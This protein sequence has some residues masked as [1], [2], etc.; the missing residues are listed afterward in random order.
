[1]GELV[2]QWFTLFMILFVIS[3]IYNIGS[4]FTYGTSEDQSTMSSGL[5]FLINVW[6]KH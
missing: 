5:F 2:S 6:V 3:V 1:M 4:I